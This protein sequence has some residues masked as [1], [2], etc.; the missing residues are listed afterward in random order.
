MKRPL[1]ELETEEIQVC[2]E[3]TNPLRLHPHYQSLW[4]SIVTQFE[5]DHRLSDKQIRILQ[6]S[7]RISDDQSQK[8]QRGTINTNRKLDNVGNFGDRLGY[9]LLNEILPPHCEVTWGTLRPF[10]QVPNNVDLLI[11]GIGNSLFGDLLND[12]LLNAVKSAKA[13]IGIFGTQ[14]RQTLPTDKLRALLDS[15]TW[16]YARYEEDLLLYGRGRKNASHLGD[17]LINAFPMTTGS[18]D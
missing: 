6:I 16:W 11:V 5:R 12:Q 15:L 13:S 18:K 1:T 8:L 3:K 2:I 7:K 17:W 14:Y 10:T 4:N 9:H